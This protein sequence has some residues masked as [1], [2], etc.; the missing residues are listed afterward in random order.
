MSQGFQKDIQYYKFC[1]YGFLKNLRF[2]E[3]FLIL[4]LLEKNISFLQIG[5]LYAIREIF[6]NILE[7]PSGIIADVFGRKKSLV[8][9][10]LFYIISFYIFYA[11]NSFYIFIL[12]IIFYAIGDAF[13]TGTHKAMIFEYIK[14]KNWKE[15]RAHYYGHTRSWSQM[16]SAISSL[17]AASI[18]FYTG[19][20]KSIFLFSIIPY[21]L[22]LLLI[23]SYPSSL[24]GSNTDIK[25]HKIK[26][27]FFK[28]FNNHLI[29]FK[30]KQ[31]LKAIT[32]LSIHSGFHRAM[33]DYLQ[34]I[35]QT[36]ALT[37]PIMLSFSD[38]QKSA[39]IIGILYFVI[40]FLTSYITRKAGK[41]KDKM[42]STE[43]AL[44]VTMTFGL[45]IAFLSGVFFHYGFYF[46]SIL[47]YIGI[48]LIEN[49]RNPIGVEYVSELYQDDI[50]STA[51]STSSQAKSFFAAIFALVLG[52]LAD[53]FGVGIG[54]SALAILVLIS[55]PLYLIKNRS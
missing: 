1:I 12:A 37:I 50:L 29:S 40:Y 2:F 54:L 13:R 51:L 20:Y 21:L 32:N 35:I 33:K 8:V 23:L 4:F 28:V 52:Y 14:N 22:D 49:L 5:T 42:K 43:L 55:T 17:I 11:T 7:I 48:Y 26:E 25:I 16:G 45:I 34:P 44:N 3:P 18:V 41:L 15:Q 10:F 39:I 6:I 46:V 31:I 47:F 36:F 30:K 9:S 53:K 24:N 38:N 27:R 19:N